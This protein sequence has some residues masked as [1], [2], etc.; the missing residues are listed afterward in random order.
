LARRIISRPFGV[1]DE[2]PP[3]TDEGGCHDGQPP[4]I[5]QWFPTGWK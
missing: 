5:S 1:R 3:A 2:V 4:S